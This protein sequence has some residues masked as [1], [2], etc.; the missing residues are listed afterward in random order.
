MKL[1]RVHGRAVAHRAQRWC[2]HSG[3]LVIGDES[4]SSVMVLGLVEVQKHVLE[5]NDGI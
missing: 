3:E 1:G 4:T 5:G 2:H